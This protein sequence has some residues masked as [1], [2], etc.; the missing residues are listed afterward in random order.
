MVGGD[1]AGDHV[2]ASQL[3]SPEQWEVAAGMIRADIDKNEVPWILSGS[4]VECVALGVA[5]RT[6][7]IVGNHDSSRDAALQCI[8]AIPRYRPPSPILLKGFLD[9][10]R[11]WWATE[12][13]LGPS[14]GRKASRQRGAGWR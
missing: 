10:T 12:P 13:G 1:K 4:A 7:V 8:D 6:R 14:P 3:Q 5:Q 2:E 9:V 11:I